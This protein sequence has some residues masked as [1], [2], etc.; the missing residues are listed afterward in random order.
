ME[1]KRSFL[2]LNGEKKADYNSQIIDKNQNY[3]NKIFRP[4][5]LVF[6]S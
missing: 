5:N 6:L 3:S 1:R 2:V 4:Y